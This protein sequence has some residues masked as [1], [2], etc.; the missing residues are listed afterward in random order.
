MTGSSSYDPRFSAITLGLLQDSGWYRV[1]YSGASSFAFGRQAGCDFVRPTCERRVGAYR[2]APADA[3]S[4]GC[5]CASSLCRLCDFCSRSFTLRSYFAFASLAAASRRSFSRSQRARRVQHP[6]VHVADSEQ[7]ASARRSVQIV[8]SFFRD[9]LLRT[10]PFP[11]DPKFGGDQL[12]DF[13]YDQGIVA[14]ALAL[15]HARSILFS[16]LYK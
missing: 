1:N 15:S 16:P 12:A 2:C 10:Q 4:V 3:H 11:N 5:T 7:S 14:C 9:H 6:R 13:W 8:W